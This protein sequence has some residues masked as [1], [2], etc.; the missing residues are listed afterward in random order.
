MKSSGRVPSR[1]IVDVRGKWKDLI[2][3]GL[4]GRQLTVDL[5]GVSPGT[6]D[7]VLHISWGIHRI[8]VRVNGGRWTARAGTRRVVDD[9]DGEVGI[10]VVP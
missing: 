1:V 10:L 3:L 5:A 4:I 7:G 8:A 2:R 9:Y 6:W